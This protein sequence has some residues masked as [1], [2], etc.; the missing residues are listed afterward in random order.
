MKKLL[1]ISLFS[2]FF[3][4]ILSLFVSQFALLP[5]L[6]HAQQVAPD[7]NTSGQNVPEQITTMKAQVLDVASQKQ[8]NIAGTSMSETIQTL[9]LKILDGAEKGKELTV[10]NDYTI[11]SA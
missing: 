1:P 5:L 3:I 6:A 8:E 9:D 4:F 11:F 10:E 2:L 7:Q